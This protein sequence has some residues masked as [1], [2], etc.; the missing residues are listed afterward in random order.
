VLIIVLAVLSMAP[1]GEVVS[2]TATGG[3]SQND[4]ITISVTVRATARVTNS[5]LYFEIRAPNGTVVDTHSTGDIPSMNNG[6]RFSYSWNSNNSSYPEMGDYTVWVCWSPGNAT[7]CGVA[8]A[9]TTFYSV[10]TMG[11]VLSVVALALLGF[12]LWRA[13]HKLFPS[14]EAAA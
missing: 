4:T 13:R 10:P 1:D 12:W 7:N 5:N 6:D 3:G 14:R 11:I 2:L 8:Q 9:S